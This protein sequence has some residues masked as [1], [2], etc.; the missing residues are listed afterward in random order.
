MVEAASERRKRSGRPHPN[1]VLPRLV[2]H[3]KSSRDILELLID[4]KTR[5]IV[6]E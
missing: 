6:Q 4:V 2:F 5:G 1:G 3:F